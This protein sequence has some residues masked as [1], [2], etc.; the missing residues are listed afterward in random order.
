MT[1]V[2]E[3]MST[4]VLTV[5]PETKISEVAKLLLE[6]K[7]NGLP[8]V[9]KNNKLIGIICQSDIVYQQ[10]KAPI[11][12]V[13]TLLDGFIPLTSTSHIEKE[14]RKISA[15]SVE[16]AMSPNP[17]SVHPDTDL[18][19]LAE[20]MIK[21]KYH[22]IPVVDQGKLIGVIGKEDVLKTLIK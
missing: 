7:I 12:S 10:K 21:K 19:D 6:K 14:L 5:G 11:P 17:V 8:V 15:I 18:E 1:K 13:F 2:S 16:Q 3:L 22:T 4:D 9:D 20:I